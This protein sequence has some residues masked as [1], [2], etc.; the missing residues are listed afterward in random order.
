MVAVVIIVSFLVVACIAA[1]FF[2]YKRVLSVEDKQA[3]ISGQCAEEAKESLTEAISGLA[4]VSA[5]NAVGEEVDLLR[6][7][8]E[9]K[10]ANLTKRGS[11]GK[12]TALEEQVKTLDI[13][14]KALSEEV[15]KATRWAD[16]KKGGTE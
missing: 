14:L 4:T 7:E 12:L 3:D 10:I 13:S 2:V 16:G 11:R 1:V 5:L 15:A 8:T 9:T 6:E